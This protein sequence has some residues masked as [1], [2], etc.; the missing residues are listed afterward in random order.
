[1]DS[2]SS[3]LNP[4]LV[5]GISSLLWRFLTRKFDRI[6]RQFD[7]IDTQFERVDAKFDRFD[8]KL[9]D[10]TREVAANGK[11]LARIEGRHES[12]PGPITD[13]PGP[14]KLTTL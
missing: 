3:W 6:D 14:R 9:G 10:L 8:S 1:M 2:I 11:S 13:P 7:R 4:V 5:V 12:H